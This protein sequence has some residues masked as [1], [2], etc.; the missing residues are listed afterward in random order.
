MSGAEASTSGAAP[1]RQAAPGGGKQQQ[2]AGD[3]KRPRRQKAGKGAGA[4]SGVRLVIESPEWGPHAEAGDG[5]VWAPHGSRLRNRS[6][7]VCR[8]AACVSYAI[9]RKARAASTTPASLPAVHHCE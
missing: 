6:A 1:T 2:G 3:E 4:G 8:T 5:D 7:Y 9:S